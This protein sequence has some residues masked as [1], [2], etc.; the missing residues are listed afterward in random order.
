[1]YI[2]ILTLPVRRRENRRIWILNV[3]KKFSLV[4]IPLRNKFWGL[5]SSGMRRCVAGKW[6]STFRKFSPSS[7]Q[8]YKPWTTAP[9]E[10]SPRLNRCENLKIRKWYLIRYCI[11]WMIC[12]YFCLFMM[13]I[14]TVYIDDFV[15]STQWIWTSLKK[16]RWN[17]LRYHLSICVGMYS[18]FNTRV[19]PHTSKPRVT[20]QSF[21]QYKK[22]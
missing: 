22:P 21:L 20:C 18:P 13:Y 2:S 8:G 7:V 11:Y 4:L 1:M 14:T 19:S 5:Q 15:W 9:E 12:F 6:F 17:N 16:R 3:K 10:R